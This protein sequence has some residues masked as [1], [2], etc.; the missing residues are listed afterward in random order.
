MREDDEQAGAELDERPEEGPTSAE[1]GR[2]EHP[3]EGPHDDP[4]EG[5][6]THRGW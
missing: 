5:L 2:S 3:G 6:G 4:A 1:D